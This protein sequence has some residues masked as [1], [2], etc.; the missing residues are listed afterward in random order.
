MNATETV[1]LLVF[2]LLHYYSA[3]LSEVL[4]RRTLKSSQE[5]ARTSTLYTVGAVTEVLSDAIVGFGERWCSRLFAAH[6]RVCGHDA[7]QMDATDILLVE[8]TEDGQSVNVDF[9]ESN[10]RLDAWADRNGGVPEIIIV[11]GF[12][13]SNAAGQVCLV[14]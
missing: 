11:T 6:L 14:F 3:R 2:T 10:D 12:I 13:A 9:D 8:P 5:K 7:L 4:F 1:R